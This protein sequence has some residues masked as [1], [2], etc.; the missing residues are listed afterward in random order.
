MAHA[1]RAG[2]QTEREMALESNCL[3]TVHHIK[4][5]GLTAKYKDLVHTSGQMAVNLMESGLI[6][7]LLDLDCIH[8][9]MDVDM[10][11]SS[12]MIKG[13]AMEYI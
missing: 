6:K 13:K 11:V 9:R 4:A 3:T 1:S 12:S 7:K 10:K 2:I 5:I 8:G